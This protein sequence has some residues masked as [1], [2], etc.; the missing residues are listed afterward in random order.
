MRSLLCCLRSLLCCLLF[1]IFLTDRTTAGDGRDLLQAPIFLGISSAWY[2]NQ[3]LTACE[4]TTNTATSVLPP[5]SYLRSRPAIFANNTPPAELTYSL[6]AA[7]MVLQ[8]D[9]FGSLRTA[10][11]KDLRGSGEPQMAINWFVRSVAYDALASSLKGYTRA[12]FPDCG[13]TKQNRLAPIR[14]E[15]FSLNQTA[16]DGY[17]SFSMTPII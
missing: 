1:A 16:C 7:F 14:F 3:R 6:T 9:N 12:T 5:C 11:V 8:D 17:D 2:C 15:V 4:S 10:V 13:D